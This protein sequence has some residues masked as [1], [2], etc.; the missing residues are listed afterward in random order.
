MLMIINFNLT[1]RNSKFL[2]SEVDDGLGMK[3]DGSNELK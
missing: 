2:K 3:M 1:R